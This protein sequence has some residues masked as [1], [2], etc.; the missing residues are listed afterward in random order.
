MTINATG[1]SLSDIVPVGSGVGGYGDVNVQFMDPDG[2]WAGWYFWYTKA[3][4]Q[5]AEDGWYDEDDQL[6]DVSLG[7]GKSFVLAWKNHQITNR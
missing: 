6:A 4:W 2:E 5:V 3:G 1:Y 7:P